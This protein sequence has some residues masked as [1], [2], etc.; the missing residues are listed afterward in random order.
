MIHSWAGCVI[1]Q[2]SKGIVAN[3]NDE[4]RE[5]E[6]VETKSTGRETRRKRT[7]LP[8]RKTDGGTTPADKISKYA[9][10]ILVCYCPVIEL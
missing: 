2:Q 6:T 1:H 9:N 3:T 8:L 7:T 4:N 10:T 5:K